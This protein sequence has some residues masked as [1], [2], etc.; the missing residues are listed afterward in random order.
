ME[1][2]ITDFQRLDKRK[3][4]EYLLKTCKQWTAISPKILDNTLLETMDKQIRRLMNKH[5]N[6]NFNSQKSG[7]ILDLLKKHRQAVLKP[8]YSNLNTF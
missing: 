7:D 1:K 4:L 8:L 6:N 5:K 2:L 3:I